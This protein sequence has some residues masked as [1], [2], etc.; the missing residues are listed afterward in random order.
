MGRDLVSL[1]ACCFVS[2]LLLCTHRTCSCLLPVA[3][4]LRC[5]A[6]PLYPRRFN[7]PELV[8]VADAKALK[9]PLPTNLGWPV[10]PV[11]WVLRHAVGHLR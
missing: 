1:H 7:G 2:C 6:L 8:A 10:S 5:Y 11:L 3:M 9:L 4:W